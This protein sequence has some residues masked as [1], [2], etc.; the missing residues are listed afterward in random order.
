MATLKRN[1]ALDEHGKI[2]DSN[3]H[4]CIAVEFCQCILIQICKNTC[5][6]SADPARLPEL[7]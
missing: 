6:S 2:L 1:G 7:Y 5:C 3:E 4:I